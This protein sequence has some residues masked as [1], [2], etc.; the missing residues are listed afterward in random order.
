MK[1]IRNW[2]LCSSESWLYSARKQTC[3]IGEQ[4]VTETV[5]RSDCKCAY[6]VSMHYLHAL[7][8]TLS[9]RLGSSLKY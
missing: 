1:H 2:I 6:Q 9:R 8:A 7:G 5:K 4:I 3:E